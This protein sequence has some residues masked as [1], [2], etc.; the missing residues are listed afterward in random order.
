MYSHYSGKG[1]KQL[2]DVI[3]NNIKIQHADATKK[4]NH[5]ISEKCIKVYP[6]FNAS[7]LNACS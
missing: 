4:T 7:S 2:R 6:A 3:V 1:Q 5:A